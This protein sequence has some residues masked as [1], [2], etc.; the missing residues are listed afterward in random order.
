MSGVWTGGGGS[1]RKSRDGQGVGTKPAQ[2]SAAAT[3]SKAPWGGTWREEE[4]E[5][6]EREEGRDEAMCGP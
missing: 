1:Q 4:E 5:E 6:E 3:V 2:S